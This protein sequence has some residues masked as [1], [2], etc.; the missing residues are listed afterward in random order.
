VSTKGKGFFDVGG[1]RVERPEREADVYSPSSAKVKH[2][3]SYRPTFSH[4]E[5][6]QVVDRATFTFNFLR[7][8]WH[9]KNRLCT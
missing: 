6:L 1:G 8:K 9:G 7:K 5:G 2:D 3:G 4:R